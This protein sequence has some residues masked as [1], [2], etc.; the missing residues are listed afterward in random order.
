VSAVDTASSINYVTGATY[1]PHGA[2]AGMVNATVSGGFAGITTTNTYNKRLQPLVRSAAASSSLLNITYAFHLGSG[3]NGNVFQITNN[4]DN[5]RSQS[6]T[7]DALNRLI[8]AQSLSTTGPNCWGNSF[9]LD[10]WGNLTNKTVTKC[11]AEAL[12]A[13]PATTQ[14]RLPGFGYDAAGNMT[15]NGPDTYTY[16]AEN[17]IITA[18]GAN[19]Y[20]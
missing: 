12:S 16:D 7:Y 5:T 11:T 19:L 17:R 1:T 2:L 18:G 15:S 20:L 10:P 4:R 8:S 14:N 9:T 6:F 13:S 3:D